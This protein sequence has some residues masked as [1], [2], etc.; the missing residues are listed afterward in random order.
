MPEVPH[1]SS[2]RSGLFNQTSQPQY[3]SRA[4]DMS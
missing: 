1:A 4:I 3:N 2:G